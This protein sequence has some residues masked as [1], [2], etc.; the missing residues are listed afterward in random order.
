MPATMVAAR[1]KNV[2]QKESRPKENPHKNALL[3]GGI[4]NLKTL[5]SQKF[6]WIFP[7]KN[8]FTIYRA[9]L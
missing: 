1:R 9:A 6:E 7:V 4:K 3:Q 5:F 8:V 2:E